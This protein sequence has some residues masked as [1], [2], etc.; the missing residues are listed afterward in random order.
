MRS[1]QAAQDDRLAL[2]EPMTL[3]QLKWITIL[4]PVAFLVL[5]EAVRQTLQPELFRAWPGHLLTLGVLLLGAL[6]FSEVIFAKIQELHRQTESRNRELL[7][8]HQA[9]LDITAELSLEEVL[10]RVVDQARELAGARYGAVGV[11]GEGGRIERF[12][13]SGLSPAER[14]AIGAPPTGRGL[15]GAVFREGRPIRLPRISQ[16]PRRVGFPPHHPPMESFLGVPVTLQG[17]PIGNLYLT[18]KIDAPE[19]TEEDVFTLERFATHAAV[20]IANA[21][22]HQRLRELAI[23]EERERIA[24]EM[25]DRPAQVL[26]FVSTKAQAAR[27]LLAAGRADEARSQIDGLIE[28]AQEAYSDVRADILALKSTGTGNDFLGGLGEYLERLREQSGLAVELELEGLQ[29]DSDL[30]LRPEVELQLLRILQEALS[31]VRKHAGVSRAR[32]R[33]WPQGEAILAQVE[34]QG[35]GFDPHSPPARGTPHFG[36]SIMRERAEAVGGSLRI[37]SAPGAGTR[38]TVGMPRRA[39]AVEGGPDARSAG[40]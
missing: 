7:A 10:Q 21:R 26:G 25:H 15:L 32:L 11:L 1:F 8:L 6:V 23:T 18:E 20:A 36:L 30:G 2:A 14:E 4:A 9:A 12:L 3:K 28:L 39:Q 5:L 34:D 19:F 35:R 33:L 17:E 24:R 37:T 38:V 22:L 27:E 31:N 13:T 29:G 40:R 16:D